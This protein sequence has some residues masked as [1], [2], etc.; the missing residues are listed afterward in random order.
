M[1]D[2]TAWREML[3]REWW[4]IAAVLV[5]A[6]AAAAAF[7]LGTKP[8]TDAITEVNC[9]QRLLTPYP[10]IPTEDILSASVLYPGSV[11]AIAKDAGTTTAKVT[12][13]LQVAYSPAPQYGVKLTAT[14][15]DASL[16]TRISNAAAAETIAIARELQIV[17][18]RSFSSRLQADTQ[19]LN[20]IQ[21]ALKSAPTNANLAFELWTVQTATANDQASVQSLQQA[22]TIAGPA[23]LV[24]PSLS[25][26]L[27]T[28]VAVGLLGLVLGL[29]LAAAR[30]GLLRRR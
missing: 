5:I 19:A 15:K 13:D 23:A 14:D 12:A 9:P 28:Y 26:T 24:A 25:K 4:L 3:R 8:T 7:K 29:I 16:A 20:V 1:T 22:Y 27:E 2:S 11:A 30:E 17:T 6:L 21:A 10:S 18:I